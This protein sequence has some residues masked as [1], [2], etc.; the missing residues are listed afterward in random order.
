MRLSYEKMDRF[1]KFTK[2]KSGLVNETSAEIFVQKKEK[3]KI[4]DEKD[5]YHQY[6]S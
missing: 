6:N 4:N 1:L 2:Q 5:T 3:K